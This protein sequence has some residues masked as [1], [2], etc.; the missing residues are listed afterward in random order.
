MNQYT[1]AH[2]AISLSKQIYMTDHVLREMGVVLY[3]V[4]R[5]LNYY[6]LG[7]LAPERRALLPGDRINI[8]L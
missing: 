2:L 6:D 8:P 5:T 4:P 3:S 1:I 7:V